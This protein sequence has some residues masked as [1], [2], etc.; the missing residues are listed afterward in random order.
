MG[1]FWMG[2]PNHAMLV[3]SLLS[4][5]S[6]RKCVYVVPAERSERMTLMIARTRGGPRTPAWPASDSSTQFYNSTAGHSYVRGF[7]GFSE[8]P[9]LLVNCIE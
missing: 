4:R 6:Q 5:G 2:R 3:A 9:A 8:V 1:Y 7:F